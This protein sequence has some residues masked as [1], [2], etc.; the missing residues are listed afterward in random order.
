MK[1]EYENWILKLNMKIKYENYSIKRKRV[2][3]SD[4][5]SKIIPNYFNKMIILM[6]MNI[7]INN[8]EVITAIKSI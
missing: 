8:K 5:I 2:G 4:E 3:R 6:M 7:D 1:I